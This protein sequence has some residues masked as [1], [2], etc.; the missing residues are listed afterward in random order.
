MIRSRAKL[1]FQ[2]VALLAPPLLFVLWV[3]SG[4]GVRWIAEHSK[5]FQDSLFSANSMVMALI[6]LGYLMTFINL[7]FYVAHIYRGAF[8]GP[9]STEKQRDLVIIFV[10]SVVLM[11]VIGAFLTGTLAAFLGVQISFLKFNSVVLLNHYFVLGVLAV[12][13]VMDWRAIQSA[14]RLPARPTS[15][16]PAAWL[17]VWLVSVPSI[18]VTLLALLLHHNLSTNPDWM[19]IYD[20]PEILSGEKYGYLHVPLVNP[21]SEEM[22]MFGLF[23]SG[24][25]VGLIMASMMVSQIA[26]FAIE[27]FR[28]TEWTERRKKGK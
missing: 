24:L 15:D 7:C 4:S 9:P 14:Q 10:A 11:F 3:A 6:W 22:P 27:V 18:L 17:S 13:V 25:N 8:K 12:F 5:G 16:L 23:I 2:G 21:S 1:L 20:K 26:F 19:L 28:N